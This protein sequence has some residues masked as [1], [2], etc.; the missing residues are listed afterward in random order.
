MIKELKWAMILMAE[1]I[2]FKTNAK[3]GLG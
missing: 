2:G 3:L 1:K